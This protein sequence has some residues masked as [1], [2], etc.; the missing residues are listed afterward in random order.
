M[1][2]F[3]SGSAA[4]LAVDQI[5]VAPVI[6]AARRD[7]DAEFEH[8][9]SQLAEQSPDAQASQPAPS[10]EAAIPLPRSRPAEAN[11]ALKIDPPPAR[12]RRAD[13]VPK[14]ADLVPLR[15]TLASLT[16]GDEV[17]Q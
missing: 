1:I 9:E 6:R 4:Q 7:F 12:S 5:P 10:V 2:R 17:V 3:G 11:L 16:P 15:L 14:L 13:H 8:I